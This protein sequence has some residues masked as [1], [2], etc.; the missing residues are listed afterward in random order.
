MAL[1]A[2]IE[3]VFVLAHRVSWLGASL[4]FSE[5]EKANKKK[6]AD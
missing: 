1:S 6:E 2:G 3:E 5:V 4:R